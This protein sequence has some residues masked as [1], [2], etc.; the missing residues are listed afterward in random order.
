MVTGSSALEEKVINLNS[1]FTCNG[2]IQVADW[3]IH[4]WTRGDHGT[5]DFTAAMTNSCNPAFVQI[6]Q[7]LGAE[8]FCNY[9]AAF[10][11]FAPYLDLA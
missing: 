3:P 10:G 5:Q 4:C 2:V 7:A 1:T 9:F 6:G 11:L 8:N